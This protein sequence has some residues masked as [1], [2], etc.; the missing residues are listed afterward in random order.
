MDIAPLADLTHITLLEAA[1]LG[2]L[3]LRTVLH[4]PVSHKKTILLPFTLRV[5]SGL[6]VIALKTS[7]AL[8]TFTIISSA[9]SGDGAGLGAVGGHFKLSQS[10]GAD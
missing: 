5:I 10:F 1:S 3:F 2:T 9:G 7:Q 4:A 8:Y 6:V